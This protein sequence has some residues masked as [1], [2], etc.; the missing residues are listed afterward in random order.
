MDVS[1]G[2]ES[3]RE[4]WF[5]ALRELEAEAKSRSHS[6]EQAIKAVNRAGSAALTKQTASDW[7][8][9][10]VP[11]DFESIW[12]LITVYVEWTERPVDRAAWK[13]LHGRARQAGPAKPSSAVNRSEQWSAAVRNH[14]AW[15]LVADETH[16]A[17]L[18]D[19]CARAAA[20]L[21]TACDKALTDIDDPWR[22]DDHPLRFVRHVELV[23][24]TLNSEARLSPPEAAAVVLLP[25]L[26]HAQR[27]HLTASLAPKVQ[28]WALGSV[29]ES[30]DADERGAFDGYL[31]GHGAL[32]RRARQGEL[33]GRTNAE[34]E[35]GWWLFHRWAAERRLVDAAQARVLLSAVPGLLGDVAEILEPDRL[36]AF[37]AGIRLA[38]A[39]L[40]DESSLRL[41][42]RAHVDLGCVGGLEVLRERTVGLVVSIGRA[43][44][45]DLVELPIVLVEHLGIPNPVQLADVRST[46]AAAKWRT[47]GD[48]DWPSTWELAAECHHPAVLEALREHAAAVEELLTSVRRV[49]ANGGDALTPLRGL[50]SFA[51]AAKAAPAHDTAGEAKF[52][53]RTARFT[54]DERQI[55]ELLMGTQL[56]GSPNLAIRELYQNALDACRYRR[57]REQYV[58]C[59][60]NSQSTYEGE[61][62]FEQGVDEDGRAYIECQDNGVGMGEAEL[63]GVFA[64]AGVGFT[65]LPEFVEEQAE[66][67]RHG[68]RMYPNSRFGVGVLSY[69]MLADEIT[70]TSRRMPRS[71]GLPGKRWRSAIVGP[72]HLFDVRP[73]ADGGIGAG[74]TVRLYLKEE[75]AIRSNVLTSALRDFLVEAEFRTTVV[76][77]RGGWAR[78]IESWPPGELHP[79]VGLGRKVPTTWQ[80]EGRV[81]WCAERSMLLVDGIRVAGHRRARD[82]SLVAGAVVNLAGGGQVRLS[83][84][85]RSVA[86]DVSDRVLRLMANAADE[87]VRH[88]PGFADHA[89]VSG[90][91]DEDHRVAD[92]VTEA[93]IRAG[94]CWSVN[95]ARYPVADTGAFPLDMDWLGFG[96][97]ATRLNSRRSPSPQMRPLWVPDHIYLWRQLAFRCGFAWDR[98]ESNVAALRNAPAVL[99]ALPSDLAIVNAY[100]RVA[101][102]ERGPEQMTPRAMRLGLAGLESPRLPARTWLRGD[103]DE[104]PHASVDMD[105]SDLLML[106]KEFDGRAPWFEPGMTM[107]LHR[108]AVAAVAFDRSI[109]S[110]VARLRHLGMHCPDV[111]D[112]VREALKR[113]PWRDPDASF[114]LDSPTPE[115]AAGNGH[116]GDGG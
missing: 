111:R 102:T 24:R 72:G 50:P 88:E 40:S 31:I 69:F 26:D 105:G 104:V 91:A 75:S 17:P 38:P 116:L 13:T 70:V 66:W 42:A 93:A 83:V 54:L 32:V 56:Y 34:A 47:R 9:A 96:A 21:A 85:R 46:V 103:S 30:V 35:I 110:V 49:A 74:T 22:D 106:S 52:G 80:D 18:R 89:W 6:R 23:L 55:R 68:I 99:A 65:G 33:P 10:T 19:E 76:E 115:T 59:L 43:L 60:T 7:F 25:F 108:V 81:V 1:G 77:L 58:A 53:A 4:A 44:A 97:T 15:R 62:R 84:D 95:G 28:P 78:E 101:S 29:P 57:A 2:S 79:A 63:T 87:L 12:P 86:E 98:L 71:G 107:S 5:A 27:T 112:M 45:L 73:I 20:A 67:A 39:R 92:I 48:G 51:S 36:A 14:H 94:T 61:I 113:V 37:L 82:R 100:T 8:R 90:V 16:I 41:K 3:D 114:S 11:A 64:R 109:D